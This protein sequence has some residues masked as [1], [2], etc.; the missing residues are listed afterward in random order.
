META[1]SFQTLLLTGQTAW[2]HIRDDGLKISNLKG[3]QVP[4]L[5]IQ[6]LYRNIVICNFHFQLIY[7][8]YI[9]GNGSQNAFPILTSLQM[10]DC[11]MS[12]CREYQEHSVL[13]ENDV[14]KL[15]GHVLQ[16]ISFGPLSSSS[17]FNNQG[18]WPFVGPFHP[19]SS[20]GFLQKFLCSCF[21]SCGSYFFQLSRIV[22]LCIVSVYA[23]VGR[24]ILK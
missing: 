19:Q 10:P 2:S 16:S 17:T 18:F 20:T 6:K 23:L 1:L 21:A 4:L 15:I 24:I 8:L 11:V 9:L 12:P 7:L 3:Y 14:L 13:L 5:M 22:F